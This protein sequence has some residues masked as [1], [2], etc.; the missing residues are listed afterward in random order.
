[1]LARYGCG[2]VE[3]VAGHG[4]PTGVL[5]VVL[6]D[7][8]V[9]SPEFFASL[10]VSWFGGYANGS[11]VRLRQHGCFLFQVAHECIAKEI[12]L[13][14]CWRSGLLSVSM[15]LSGLDLSS[16]PPL[17]QVAGPSWSG[18]R[19]RAWLPNSTL[20]SLLGLHPLM[21]QVQ[22]CVQSMVSS[23]HAARAQD[24]GG[25]VARLHAARSD[26]CIETPVCNQLPLSSRPLNP[27]LPPAL[28]PT[29]LSGDVQS[30]ESVG[31][32]RS[33]PLPSRLS[34]TPDPCRDSQTINPAN[35]RHS[36]Y[37]DALLSTSLAFPPS[38]GH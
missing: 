34:V 18:A 33:V 36:T 28:Q 16:C 5:A 23:S 13:R 27:L 19:R 6:N 37:G 38:R 15:S 30:H 32:A 14:E 29:D 25:S 12:V 24:F 10:L 4:S 22:P 3:P 7:G 17:A 11:H 2:T 8:V 26:P 9:L 31:H 35:P 1:M 20:P 21:G